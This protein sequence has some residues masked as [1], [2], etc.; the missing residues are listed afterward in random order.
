VRSILIALTAIAFVLS[1]AGARTKADSADPYVVV[2]HGGQS[3]K[4]H[5]LTKNGQRQLVLCDYSVLVLDPKDAPTPLVGDCP[6][7]SEPGTKAPIPN[8]PH[9]LSTADP[10]R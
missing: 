2:V 5:L 1:V 3:F 8:G 10:R 9:G 4:G 6:R 7:H